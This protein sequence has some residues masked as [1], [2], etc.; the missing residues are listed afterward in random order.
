MALARVCARTLGTHPTKVLL[1]LSPISSYREKCYCSSTYRYSPRVGVVEVE[2]KEV[3]LD[4]LVVAS[5]E[6]VEETV[7]ATRVRGW[8]VGRHEPP[9]LFTVRTGVHQTLAACNKQCTF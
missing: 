3:N 1:S 8:P 4:D 2:V 6:G 7:E 5:D 9:V